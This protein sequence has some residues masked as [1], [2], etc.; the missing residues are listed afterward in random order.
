V[1]EYNSVILLILD[2]MPLNQSVD[3]SLNG[4]KRRVVN[5]DKNQIETRMDELLV[6]LDLGQ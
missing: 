5:H 2:F 6:A 4:L 1:R 3:M